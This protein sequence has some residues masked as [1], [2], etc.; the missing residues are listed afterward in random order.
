LIVGAYTADTGG[1]I[2]A[3]AHDIK[4]VPHTHWLAID[5]KATYASG[6]VW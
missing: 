1:S 3:A 4:V 2:Y 6:N 5:N